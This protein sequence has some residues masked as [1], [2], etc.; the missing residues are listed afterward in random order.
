MREKAIIIVPVY[1]ED[2]NIEKLLSSIKDLKLEISKKV[3]VVDD[4]SEDNTLALARKFK[5]KLDLKI[6]VHEQNKGIPQTFYDGLKAAADSASSKDVIFIIEG[7]NTS[8]LSLFPQIIQ[9]IRNG[10]DIVV[11][12]RYLKGGRYKNFP[13][14]RKYGSIFINYVL[15][16]FFYTRGVS[17]YTIFYR[18]YSAEVVKNA[19]KKYGK[20]FITTKSF[21]ANLEILLRMKAFAK[22][23][24]E[25]PMVYDYGLKKGKSKMKIGK[26]LFEYRGLIVQRL[27][28]K[29]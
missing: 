27:L 24:D 22:K 7:D 14:H 4:G 20:N 10:A 26:A 1:N 5:R 17:D 2:G 15:K 29:I 12:S 11:A 25:V 16:T 21:A 28:H 9:K 13:L 6:I 18:A 3:I 8:D 19:L 23:Y